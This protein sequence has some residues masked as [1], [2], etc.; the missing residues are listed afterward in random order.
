MTELRETTDGA[1]VA[2]AESL[3][4]EVDI[5]KRAAGRRISGQGNPGNEIAGGLQDVDKVWFT[6]DC[7]LDLSIVESGRKPGSGGTDD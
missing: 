7:N 4:I 5:L 1:V 2:G 6:S 3:R